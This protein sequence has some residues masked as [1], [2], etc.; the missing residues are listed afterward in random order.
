MSSFQ[1]DSARAP[2]NLI[3]GYHDNRIIIKVEPIDITAVVGSY[4]NLSVVIK[5]PCPTF[6]WYNRLGERIPGKTDSNL[7]IGPIGEEDFGFYRLEIAD[8]Y[9]N[10][11]MLSRWVELKNP[12]PPRQYT[13]PIAPKLLEAPKGGVFMRGSTVNLTGYFANASHYQW[14]KDGAILTGCDGNNLMISNSGV[15]NT[16]QYVLLAANEANQF[17]QVS[18]NVMIK[19]PNPAFLRTES[20]LS[21]S[22]TNVKLVHT[23]HHTIYRDIGEAVRLETF[24][25]L[26]FYNYY[27]FKNDEQINFERGHSLEYYC[28]RRNTYG[29][30][31]CRYQDTNGTLYLEE[32][33][34]MPYPEGLHPTHITPYCQS[35]LHSPQIEP[36]ISVRKLSLYPITN[37]SRDTQTPINQHPDT[38]E[39]HIS[40]QQ[41]RMCVPIPASCVR[42]S[43]API[44]LHSPQIEPHISVRKL[45][46]YPITNP[47]KHSLQIQHHPSTCEG[48]NHPPT[49]PSLY[50]QLI[51]QND[52]ASQEE[53][54]FHSQH[55][56]SI[57]PYFPAQR[58]CPPIPASCVKERI[59]FDPGSL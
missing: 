31:V 28:I 23:Y 26:D 15:H 58:M 29:T 13:Q 55:P 27:W 24:C 33:Q 2:E 39:P 16:G 48:Y 22:D 21:M 30:Y 11:I 12:N 19:S 43:S 36:H 20:N 40:V 49:I 37:P 56:D 57:E 52:V 3:I 17:V 10:Q 6:Q 1:T 9:L 45:S 5:S 25:K 14:Y 35:R 32:F 38:I 54:Q 59:Q 51:S 44:L 46:L 50:S 8:K 53:T 7:F 18:V 42:E 47:S 4:V 41:K 34:L